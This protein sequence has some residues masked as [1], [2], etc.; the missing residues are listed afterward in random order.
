MPDLQKCPVCGAELEEH[1][2]KTDND[3]EYWTFECCAMIYFHHGKLF[4][5]N[6]C[7]DITQ[8]VIDK[9]N[10]ASGESVAASYSEHKP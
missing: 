10:K 3:H 8:I 1:M 4:V 6:D 5:D 9:I 7:E 2:P